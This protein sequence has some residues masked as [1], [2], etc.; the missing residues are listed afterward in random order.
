[1]KLSRSGKETQITLDDRELA[2]LK[3][4]LERASFIDTP[5]AEQEAILTFAGKALEQIAALE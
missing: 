2:L 3:R 4:A 1:M 5:V